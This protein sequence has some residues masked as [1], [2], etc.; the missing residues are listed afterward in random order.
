MY[1]TIAE[2]LLEEEAKAGRTVFVGKHAV[3]L[4]GVCQGI[5][6]MVVMADSD[7][8][9]VRVMASDKTIIETSWNNITQ[10]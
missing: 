9:R 4:S 5:T 3:I 6:G 8:R 1:Q 10:R 2:L 7:T